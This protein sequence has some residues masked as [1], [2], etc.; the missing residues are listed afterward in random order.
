MLSIRDFSGED[1]YKFCRNAYDDARYY[2]KNC[3]IP[4]DKIDLYLIKESKKTIEI[5][6][7]YLT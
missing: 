5:F 7:K 4:R 6:K 3:G 1:H 2:L